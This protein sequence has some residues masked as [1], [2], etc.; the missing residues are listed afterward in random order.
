M[1]DFLGLVTGAALQVGIVGEWANISECD[2]E[3]IV[4]AGTGDYFFLNKKK[5]K[6]KVQEEGVWVVE[7]DTVKFGPKDSDNISKLKVSAYT[8]QSISFCKFN[9]KGEVD[10]GDVLYVERCGER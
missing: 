5:E 4:F 10:C 1:G 3:R 7:N 9:N 2:S 8:P 6:W